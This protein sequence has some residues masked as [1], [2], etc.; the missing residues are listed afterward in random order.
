MRTKYLAK[1]YG[2][3]Y[4]SYGLEEMEAFTSI[5]AAKDEMW[6]RLNMS[7]GYTTMYRENA[8]GYYVKWEDDIKYDL[9]GSTNEDT[10]ELYGVTEFEPG[11]FIRNAEPSYRLSHG[12]RKGVVKENY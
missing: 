1:Y 3:S 5:Q 9:P 6:R 12:P 4:F 7:Y 11:V 10:M 2:P 8:Q